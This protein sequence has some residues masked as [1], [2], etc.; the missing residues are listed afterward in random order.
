MQT[1]RDSLKSLADA[2]NETLRILQAEQAERAKKPRLALYVGNA[3]LDKTA[4]HLKPRGGVAQTMAS[5]DLLLKNEGDAPVSTFRL[6]ALVPGDV[7][8]NSNPLLTVPEYEPSANPSSHTVTLQ[9]PPLPAGQK[10]RIHVE[11]IV[12]NG[13]SLFKIPFT[14]DALEMQ[15]VAPLGSLTVLPPKL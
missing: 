15:A 1:A 9:L 11:I 7:I 12:P 13:H 5:L 3:L 8:L 14:V 2:Q 4:I 6:H 10:V